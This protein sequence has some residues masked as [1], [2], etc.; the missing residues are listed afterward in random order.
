MCICLKTRELDA[1]MNNVKSTTLRRL[2]TAIHFS[3]YNS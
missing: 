1:C 3:L 2:M